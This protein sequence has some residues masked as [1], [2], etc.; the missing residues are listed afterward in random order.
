MAEKSKLATDH[1]MAQAGYGLE[2]AIGE[3]QA[4][5]MIQPMQVME[6]QQAAGGEFRYP[7]WFEGH[8]GKVARRF[9]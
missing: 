3:P 9:N 2:P 7:V 5:L 8:C 4:G 6:A 1:K